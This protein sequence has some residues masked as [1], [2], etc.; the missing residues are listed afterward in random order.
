MNIT[1]EEGQEACRRL[2]APIAPN[3]SWRWPDDKTNPAVTALVTAM[4]EQPWVPR[5]AVIDEATLCFEALRAQRLI[6]WTTLGI[7]THTIN[8]ADERRKQD[9]RS[10][11]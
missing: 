5:M 10:A 9:E 3:I 1:D 8:W 6:D 11:V 7:I 4:R 2:N